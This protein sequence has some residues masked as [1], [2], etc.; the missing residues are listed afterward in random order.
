MKSKKKN[1]YHK[2]YKFASSQKAQTTVVSLNYKLLFYETA[3]IITQCSFLFVFVL[4]TSSSQPQ[5][6]ELWGAGEM[7][8]QTQDS[9]SP[10]QH[11][12]VCWSLGRHR[13]FCLPFFYNNAQGDFLITLTDL[14]K[15]TWFRGKGVY[16]EK[17]KD[18]ASEILS[19]P[20]A[21]SVPSPYHPH[22]EHQ[23]YWLGKKQG[24]M[25]PWLPNR[26]MRI[27]SLR[28]KRTNRSFRKSFLN[29]NKNNSRHW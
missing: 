25:L 11:R 8:L 6:W 17:V 7:C 23:L 2:S 18:R 15:E 21:A 9:N 14:W 10:G 12:H 29:L 16:S 3:Y 4:L 20:P 27:Y 22:A 28:K 26:V 1:N 13:W 24:G 19:P 5:K